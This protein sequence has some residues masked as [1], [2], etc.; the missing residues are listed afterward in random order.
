MT[1]YTIT[2]MRK[3][4]LR[5]LAFSN[6]EYSN[7]ITQEEADEQLKKVIEN[8]TA[9]RVA[10]LIGTDLKVMPVECYDNGDA[11]RTIF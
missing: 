4:G 6:N 9:E 3:D 2:A 5:H 8:N 7:Y 11:T 1:R 10:D